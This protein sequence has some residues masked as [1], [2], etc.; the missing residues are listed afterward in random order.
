MN[1]QM[2]DKQETPVMADQETAPDTAPLQEETEVQPPLEE[3]T[4]EPVDVEKLMA[5]LE[6][7]RRLSDE[8]LNLAQRVQADFDNYRRRNNAAR[9]EAFDEGAI[10]IIKMLLPVVDNFER[11]LEASVNTS[12]TALRDGVAMVYKQL[13]EVFEKRGVEP[14]N[15]LGEKFDPTLENAVMTAPKDEGEPGTVCQVLQKGYKL[16]KTILRHAMVKVV[17]E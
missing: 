5:D 6:E 4:E 10:S 14:I 2:Q 12:D 16:D 11:A 8:Y 7:A 17:E 9:A 3:K 13:S 15:R 1:Q